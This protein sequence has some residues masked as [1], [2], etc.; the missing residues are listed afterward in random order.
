MSVEQAIK[1]FYEQIKGRSTQCI[2]VALSGGIDSV[3]L[4]HALVYQRPKS[5]QLKA[6]HVNH[7]WSAQ[8]KDWQKFCQSLCQTLG[9]ELVIECVNFQQKSSEGWE[10]QARYQRYRV[11]EAYIDRQDLLLTAHHQRDQAETVLLQLLRGAGVEGL[12]GMPKQRSLGNAC[13]HRP[14]LNVPADEIQAYAKHQALNWVED[15]S[16]SNIELRRNYIRHQVLPILKTVWPATD[17]VLAQTSERM[18]QTNEFLFEVLEKDHRQVVLASGQLDLSVL[19]TWSQ[20]HCYHYLYYWLKHKLGVTVTHC[21][22]QTVLYEVVNAG[23][24]ADP[25]F[26]LNDDYQL[27]RYQQVL[28]LVP[29][30]SLVDTQ[31]LIIDWPDNQ[32]ELTLPYNLGHLKCY[33]H[34]GAG[35]S[36]QPHD[37]LTIR[38]RQGGE[39]LYLPYRSG[40]KSLKK[41]FQEWQVPP[42]QR[43]RIPLLYINGYLAAVVGYATHRAFYVESQGWVVENRLNG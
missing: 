28:Y 26:Q 35:L 39:K 22:L 27:R 23:E 29:R 5:V 43:S 32:N 8:A 15:P 9:V 36:L 7:Q 6:I 33:Q 37:S 17:S 40:Q 38:F 20:A 1:R 12:S 18:H 41:L 2:W 31:N 42:W 24:D 3:V 21:Q 19:K 14:L 25:C 30:Q 34:A 11:F 4:L 13:L 10:A 16:N